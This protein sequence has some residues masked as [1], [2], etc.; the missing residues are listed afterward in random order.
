MDDPPSAP[1]VTR[2]LL[3][4]HG[5]SAAGAR[6]VIAGLAGCTGLTAA[7][8]DQ[9]G[10]LARRLA[11]EHPQVTVL[12]TSPLRRAAETAEVL[13]AHLGL[14]V[15]VEPDLEELRP[16]AADGLTLAQIHARYGQA[17]LVQEPQRPLAP[18]GESWSGFRGRVAATLP[19][20]V[21][22]HR[23]ETLLAVSHAGFV[24]AAM[25]AL[26]DIPRPGNQTYLEVA[27]ASLTEWTHDG[28]RW[29]L[30]RFN[31]TAHLTW[32]PDDPG[33]SAPA[34]RATPSG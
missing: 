7:G 13:G 21:D 27:A 25:I 33:G 26:L 31:D 29:T 19:R 11:A 22:D 14:A 34:G 15:R 1:P 16:G 8:R 23:G 12:L 30:E 10:R 17:D 9:A 2:L 24:V 4:R 20:L 5:Q 18:G 6:G 28:H 32:Q 3:A